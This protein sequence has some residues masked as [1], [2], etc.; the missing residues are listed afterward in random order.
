MIEIVPCDYA[1]V[2][3]GTGKEKKTRLATSF[4]LKNGFLNRLLMIGFCF[5][6][7]WRVTGCS[8]SWR[9]TRKVFAR[10][11]HA[12]R[13]F[14]V[15]TSR[16]LLR[17]TDVEWTVSRPTRACR[18]ERERQGICTKTNYEGCTSH[19]RPLHNGEKAHVATVFWQCGTHRSTAS[20]SRNP[21]GVATRTETQPFVAPASRQTSR[22]R[23]YRR[24]KE[25]PRARWTRHEAG[26]SSHPLACSP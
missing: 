21:Y 1:K 18:R 11:L 25:G 9:P 26:I 20:P 13:L 14:T 15:D 6:F 17:M 3:S 4:C 12:A 16:T 22:Q 23:H 2:L 19:S 24:E 10:S 5:P 7:R 8:S